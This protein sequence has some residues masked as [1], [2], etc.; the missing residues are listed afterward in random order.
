MRWPFLG[1]I[2]VNEVTIE[3]HAFGPSPSETPTLVFLHEGL[4]SL[5]MWRDFPEALAERTGWG[6]FVFSRPGYGASS[7][8]VLPRRTAYMHEDAAFLAALFAA[9]EIDDPVLVGHSDGASIALIYAGG[10]AKPRPRALLLEAPHVFVEQLGI[11]SIAN[12]RDAFQTTD[13]ATRLQRHHELPVSHV[14]WGWND[15]WLHPDFAAWN[16]EGVLPNITV[17]TLVVQG[18]QDE[19][20]TWAQVKAIEGGVRAPVTAVRLSECGH[21]PHKDQRHATLDAMTTFLRLLGSA[22]P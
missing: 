3:A 4:G 8:A 14:F 19:Y 6:G 9:A 1:K 5:A 18:E 7:P 10:D 12:A 22:P 2:A 13:L 17:P 21:S 20:G 15:I 11:D 16:I